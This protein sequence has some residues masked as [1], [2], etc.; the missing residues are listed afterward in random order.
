LLVDEDGER[1]AEDGGDR[2]SYA[3]SKRVY[4]F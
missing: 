4:Y 3:D 2:D 1:D